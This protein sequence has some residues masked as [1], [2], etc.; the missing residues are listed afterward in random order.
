MRFSKNVPRILEILEARKNFA[1]Q[2]SGGVWTVGIGH[3]R[4]VGP[5]TQADDR[6]IDVWLREDLMVVDA[7]LKALVTI[8]LP[9]RVLDALGIFVFNIGVPAFQQSTLLRKL[10]GGDEHG[11]R[12]EL[13]RWCHVHGAENNGLKKRR[14]V[15]GL[16]WLG[17]GDRID[18]IVVYTIEAAVI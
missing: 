14:C 13:P 3:T 5:N 18:D 10:N 17:L 16:I 7:A 4:G 2:D 9:Q 8:D 11:A 12:K 6:Q 1:Y 15:E